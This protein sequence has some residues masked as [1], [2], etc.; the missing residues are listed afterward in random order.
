[1]LSGLEKPTINGARRPLLVG[2]FF[3]ANVTGMN[4]TRGYS[5]V[6]KEYD[7]S[8][9]LKAAKFARDAHKGQ[10]RKYGHSDRPYITHVIRVAGR[11]ATLPGAT[12]AMVAGAYMHD[13]VEDTNTTLSDVR[14]FLGEE[15][16]DIVDGLTNISKG[17]T[18]PRAERKRMDREHLAAMPVSVRRIKLVD[19]IDNLGEI[20]DDHETPE[21][22]TKLY[23]AETV[24][25]L[26]SLRGTDPVLEAELE[27]L[28]R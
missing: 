1:M 18:A 15:V 27:R 25:L 13:V 28:A 6:D 9:I 12:E 22:F 26:E 4:V 24:L 7:M 11:V 17:S 3:S 10:F 20:R 5:V 8:M 19:R 21:K 23:K 2:F 14:E 16:A